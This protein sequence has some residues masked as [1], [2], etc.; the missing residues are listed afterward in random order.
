MAPDELT[1]TLGPLETYDTIN[2]KFVDLPPIEVTFK[3]TLVSVS[4]WE[5]I[6]HKSFLKEPE[7]LT[8]AD[9]LLYYQC[10]ADKDFNQLYLT[11]DVIIELSKFMENKM[12]CTYLP[13]SKDKAKDTPTSEFLYFCMVS[14]NIPFEAQ[15]WNLNRLINL[16]GIC[17]IKNNPNKKSASELTAMNRKLNAER[18]GKTNG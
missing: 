8:T 16:I 11:N 5:M 12:S 4:K 1:L 10:M 17:S 7:K 15:Y 14:A 6:K 2:G 9:T 13:P 18:R 3:H